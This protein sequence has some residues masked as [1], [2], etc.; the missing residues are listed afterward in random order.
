[1]QATELATLAAAALVQGTLAKLVFLLVALG[2]FVVLGWTRVVEAGERDSLRDWMKL[3]RNR[4]T[5]PA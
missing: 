1:V 2:A 4:A 3:P 5:P